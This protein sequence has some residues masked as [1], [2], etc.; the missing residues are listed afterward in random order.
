[1]IQSLS[2]GLAESSVSKQPWNVSWFSLLMPSCTTLVEMLR[3]VLPPSRHMP[4][5]GQK[6][7]M[8]AHVNCLQVWGVWLVPPSCS[9]RSPFPV[10]Q[11]NSLVGQLSL[12]CGGLCKSTAEGTNA[13]EAQLTQQCNADVFPSRFLTWYFL[14][15]QFFGF[16]L[17][18][19][20]NCC[21]QRAYYHNPNTVVFFSGDGQPTDRW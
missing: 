3:V 4:G 2:W 13:A 9:L 20:L 8:D 12:V 7:S 16:F 21:F 15:L 1:M 10:S 18:Y 19:A 14:V 11:G 5:V 17:D 6:G